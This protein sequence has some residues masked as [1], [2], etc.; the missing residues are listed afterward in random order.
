M[1]EGK[2]PSPVFGKCT[3]GG[4]FIVHGTSDDYYYECIDANSISTIS[5]FQDANYF[6]NK[7]DHV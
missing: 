7:V 6:G 1:A 4:A 5:R 2:S 3:T